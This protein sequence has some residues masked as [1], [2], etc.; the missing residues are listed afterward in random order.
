MHYL[1]MEVHAREHMQAL[2]AEA[3]RCH[4]A[5][6][7]ERARQSAGDDRRGNLALRAVR[8]ALRFAASCL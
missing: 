6:E 2:L 7:W 8:G 5:E 1:E 4:L 3:E